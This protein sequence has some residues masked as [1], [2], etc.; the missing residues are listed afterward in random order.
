MIIKSAKVLYLISRKDNLKNKLSFKIANKSLPL[1]Y[2]PVLLILLGIILLQ[3]SIGL[4]TS[5][6]IRSMLAILKDRNELIPIII[7]IFLIFYWFSLLFL[8]F[9]HFLHFVYFFI[10]LFSAFPIF[11]LFP[12]KR[13][14]FKLIYKYV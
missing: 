5:M 3:K 12:I 9:L 1:G 2:T 7:L 8:I 13:L 6:M 11:C 10:F 4:I 14:Q